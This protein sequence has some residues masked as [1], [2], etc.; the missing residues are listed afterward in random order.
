MYI[1]SVKTPGDRIMKKLLF[2]AAAILLLTTSGCHW[3]HSE[4]SYD[5]FSARFTGERT[6]LYYQDRKWE[7][8]DFL[9][10]ELQEHP[11][12]GCADLV[13]FC[14][15]AAFGIETP[16]KERRQAFFAGYEKILPDSS[17][18][19]IQVTSPDTARVNTA[20]WKAAGLPPEWLF[21]M[22]VMDGAFAD[23][24]AKMHEYLAVAESMIPES[25]LS[26]SREEFRKF[27]DAY[28]KSGHRHLHHTPAYLASTPAYQVIS[29]RMFHTIP[30]L[31]K[32]AKLIPENKD[33]KFQR[34]IAIDGR[35][36]SGK[37][38]LARQL[39][40]ILD[41]QIIHMDDFFLPPAMRNA[42]RYEEAGG[43][44]H[45]ERFKE[46]VLPHLK[47]HKAFSYR[48]FDCK[49][50]SFNGNRMIWERNWVIVEGAYSTHPEFGNYADLTVFY[51]ISEKEQMRRIFERN[52]AAAAK[53]FQNRWIPLEENYIRTFGIDKKA[54]LVLK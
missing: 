15:Q 22:G 33:A 54:D 4:I 8:R 1:I 23:G 18:P 6:E 51:D 32:A 21:R 12:M 52:G 9:K 5:D 34:I 10:Q 24:E 42:A 28:T 44:V 20:A 35:S 45:Y 46:E 43:N 17:E 3:F 39:K 30:V 27:A 16:E 37:T 19:M 36:A 38:T 11:E 7:F 41:G 48:V 29:T 31:Q 47:N 50:N 13:K 40:T 14:C 49:K 2:A 26:F 25:K 53:I